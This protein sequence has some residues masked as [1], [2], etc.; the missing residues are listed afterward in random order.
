MNLPQR[1]K[2]RKMAVGDENTM[3]NGEITSVNVLLSCL[4]FNGCGVMDICGVNE[5]APSRSGDGGNVFF[6]TFSAAG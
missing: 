4:W 6:A 2:P 3:Y 1:V 5:D